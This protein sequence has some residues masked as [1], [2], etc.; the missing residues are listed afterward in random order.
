MRDA[1]RWRK[2]GIRYSDNAGNAK[3]V[4]GD[5]S[6]LLDNKP[7]LDKAIGNDVDVTSKDV[8]D[9][10]KAVLGEQ[11]YETLSKD[12]SLT[13]ETQKE[14]EERERE[15]LTT[16][17]ELAQI[18][19]Q[20]IE[21]QKERWKALQLGLPLDEIED[22]LKELEAQKAEKMAQKEDLGKKGF[23]QQ[24]LDYVDSV[25]EKNQEKQD[26]RNEKIGAKVGEN[27]EYQFEYTKSDIEEI[28]NAYEHYYS[29]RLSLE[30][31]IYKRKLAYGKAD[32]Q[33]APLIE[34]VIVALQ[35][36]LDLLEKANEQIVA[37]GNNINTNSIKQTKANYELESRIN[38]RKA[39]AG[40]HGNFTLRDVMMNDI[41]RVGWRIANFGMVSRLISKVPQSL[42]RVK[43]TT[44]QL[45]QALMNLRVVTG[46]NREEGEALMVTY[47]KLSKQLGSTTVEVANA[48]DAWLR[49]GYSVADAENLITASMKLSKL[50]KI[51]SAQAT[52]SLMV[53]LAT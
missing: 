45:E 48:A 2:F 36:K 53:G 15:Y 18:E 34:N 40:T 33:E 29:K 17:G 8:A 50:G 11:Q 37:E 12:G 9:I 5:I 43:Q 49:Q 24:F 38:K 16:V 42:N 28:E 6:S 7:L 21:V 41:R 46:Y 22:D 3:T 20:I 10:V 31:E 13:I 30:N 52:K 19:R 26:K 39:E 32:E 44:Q 25:N 51:D 47:N 23:G 4:W 27:G 14:L 1:D 35:E